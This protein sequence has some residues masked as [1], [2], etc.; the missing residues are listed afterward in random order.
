MPVHPAGGGWQWGKHGKIYKGKN[1]KAKAEAQ[2]AAAYA[3]G[4][5]GKGKKHAKGGK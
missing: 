3:S 1:A 5:R 4:Y 2:G